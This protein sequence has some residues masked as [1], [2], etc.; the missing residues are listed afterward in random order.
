MSHAGGSCD[1][2]AV[3]LGSGAERGFSLLEVS[4]A[5]VVAGLMSWAAFSGYQAVTD[6]QERERA[7]A[8]ADQLQ[9]VIRAF[10]L[11]HGRLPCPAALPDG[12]ETTGSEGCVSGNDVGWFPYVSAELSLPDERLMARYSVYR[13]EDPVFAKDADLA[14]VK[15]RTGDASG[16]MTY[17]DVTDLIVALHNVSELPVSPART[18]LTGD[19]GAAG[20]VDCAANRVMA[21]AYWLV[22]PLQDRDGDGHRLDA[23]HTMEGRCAASPSTG[24]RFGSDDVT[25]AESPAQLAGW[26]RAHL[27]Q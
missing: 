9:S 24:L 12:Y 15:E 13:A 21:A 11:R 2:V 22:V 27:P 19:G 8:E 17:R 4:L 16:E 6:Q 14:V 25:A 26:L 5:L 3:R 10:A 20:V 23:P 1:R 7:V 18:H